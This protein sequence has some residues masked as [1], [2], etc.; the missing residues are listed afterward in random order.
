MLRPFPQF[1]NVVANHV[2]EGKNRYNAVVAEWSKRATNG[3]GGRFSYTY[4]ML[5]DNQAGEGNFYSGPNGLGQVLNSYNYISSMPA[6]ATTNYAACYNPDVDYGY[7]LLDV[8]HRL[9]LAPEARAEGL[10][11]AELVREALERTP[12]PV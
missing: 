1:G 9:I 12:V 4:S 2:T 5:K 10:A 6:C 11:G 7:G 3:W 8:P